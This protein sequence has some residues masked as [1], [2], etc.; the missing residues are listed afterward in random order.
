MHGSTALLF[1]GCLPPSSH[2]F[3]YRSYVNRR[4]N[5]ANT[6]NFTTKFFPEENPYG[7]L[8][9]MLN[10]KIINKTYSNNINR[11]ISI[12]ISTADATTYNDITQNI[13][14][15]MNDIDV[16]SMINLDA[17]P[18]EWVQFKEYDWYNQL[19]NGGT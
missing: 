19:L 3:S 5:P 6:T 12:I 4:Y 16:K 10:H 13:I 9:D 18:S 2:Y 15:N 1:Y 11:N 14:N 8:G 17:M 7:S